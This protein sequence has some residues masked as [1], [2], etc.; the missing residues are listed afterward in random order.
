MNRSLVAT[1]VAYPATPP[2]SRFLLSRGVLSSMGTVRARVRLTTAL[3]VLLVVGAGCGRSDDETT[4]RTVTDRFLAAVESGDGE[5]A[6]A[7]LSPD[8][9]A[10]LEKQEQRPCREAVTELELEGGTVVRAQ[11]YLL[12][13]MVELSSGEAAFLDQ[14]EEGWRLSAIGCTPEGG[15]PA[16]RP[17]DCELES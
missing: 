5:Q 16:D 2:A 7:Q 9:R 17:Y 11:V 14:G 12:N 8:T 10:E 13:A 4:A 6:C 3:L 15:K 1:L